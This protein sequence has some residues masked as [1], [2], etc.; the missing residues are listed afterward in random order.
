MPLAVSV[1]GLEF[2]QVPGGYKYFTPPVASSVSPASGPAY[3]GTVITITGF[4]FGAA[5]QPECRFD[6]KVEATPRT[7]EGRGVSLDLVDLSITGGE[8]VNASVLNETHAWCISPGGGRL[9]TSTQAGVQ[10]YEDIGV[11]LSLN[12]VWDPVEAVAKIPW[13]LRSIPI[14]SGFAP[15]SGPLSGGTLVSIHGYAFAKGVDYRCRFGSINRTVF[16]TFDT[17]VQQLR[18]RAPPGDRWDVGE[19]SAA[20]LEVSLNGQQYTST[21]LLFTQHAPFAPVRLRPPRGETLGGSLVRVDFDARGQSTPFENILCRFGAA[22]PSV[23]LQHTDDWALC[24]APPSYNARAVSFEHYMPFTDANNVTDGTVKLTTSGDAEVKGGVLRLTDPFGPNDYLSDRDKINMRSGAMGSAVLTLRRPYN[25]LFWFEVQFELLMGSERT[26]G[27]H[28]V[29]VCLG[30]LNETEAFGEEGAGLGLRILFRSSREPLSL[31]AEPLVESIEVWYDGEPLRNVRLGTW[32][33]TSS[34]VRVVIRHDADGLH[35]SHDGRQWIKDYQVRGWAPDKTWRLGFGARGA[36]TTFGRGPAEVYKR[37]ERHW[38]DDLRVSSGLLIAEATTPVTLSFN[39]QQY[40]PVPVEFRY[41]AMP[42]VSSVTPSTGPLAGGTLVTVS[43]SKL[44][45]GRSDSDRRPPPS[46]GEDVNAVPPGLEETDSHALGYRCRFNREPYYDVPQTALPRNACYPFTSTLSHADGDCYWG[47]QV[48]NATYGDQFAGT[49]WSLSPGGPVSSYQS[50]PYG[51]DSAPGSLACVTPPRFDPLTV[52]L[53]LSLNGQQ[54]TV[55]QLPFGFYTESILHTLWPLGGPNL[56]ETFVVINASYLSNGSDYRCRFFLTTPMAPHSLHRSESAATIDDDA[57]LVRCISPPLPS[58]VHSDYPTYPS[59]YM[60]RLHV[61]KNGQ[62]YDLAGLPFAYYRQPR[63]ILFDPPGGPIEGNTTVILYGAYS[64]GHTKFCRFGASIVPATLRQGPP[65]RLICISPSAENVSLATTNITHE[66]PVDL[67]VTLNGQQ[68]DRLG[69]YIYYDRPLFDLLSPVSGPAAGQTQVTIVGTGFLANVQPGYDGKH[70]YFCRFGR[71]GRTRA[72]SVAVGTL[73]CDS[74]PVSTVYPLEVDDTNGL[75]RIIKVSLTINDQDYVPV[76]DFQYYVEPVISVVAPPVGPILGGSSLLVTGSSSFAMPEEGREAH[77]ATYVCQVADLRFPATRSLADANQL[78][79][80]VPPLTAEDARRAGFTGGEGLYELPFTVSLNAQQFTPRSPLVTYAPS[81]PPPV[82]EGSGEANASSFAP[83][84]LNTTLRA[85]NFTYVGIL[86]PELSDGVVF[87]APYNLPTSGPVDGNTTVVVYGNQ[88]DLTGGSHYQCKIGP[89]LINATFLPNVPGRGSGVLCVTVPLPQGAYPVE[90]TLNG[91][92]FTNS[93]RDGSLSPRQFVVYEPPVFSDTFPRS[94]PTALSFHL[95]L[96]GTRF[97]NGSDYICRFA[98]T[99]TLQDYEPISVVDENNSTNGTNSSVM[100]SSGVSSSSEGES[101]IDMLS[102]GRSPD[103]PLPPPCC[104][105]LS[106]APCLGDTHSCTSATFV[107]D[108]ELRCATPSV[109]SPRVMSVRVTLN[110]Q[111]YAFGAPGVLVYPSPTLQHQIPPRSA[112]GGGT[113]VLVYGRNF[114]PTATAAK[115]SGLPTV[116]C[117]FGAQKVPAT[118]ISANLIRCFAPPALTTGAFNEI[119]IDS[120]SIAG[121]TSGTVHTKGQSFGNVTSRMLE[122]GTHGCDGPRRAACHTS[123]LGGETGLSLP[124]YVYG[125]KFGL[126]GFTQ[127]SHLN[128]TTASPFILYEGARFEDGRLKL[129]R[130][131]LSGG[132]TD[133]VGFATLRH[134]A[135][136][137]HPQRSFLFDFDLR[138]GGFEA[139]LGG[140]GEGFAISYGDVPQPP[141][142]IGERGVGLGL[143]ILF[144]TYVHDQLSVMWQGNIMHTLDVSR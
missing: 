71:H 67:Y 100:A 124:Y 80:V 7:V 77:F 60:A 12:G 119:R 3:G 22:S 17:V 85:I 64:G 104:S 63:P 73:R 55:D 144:R 118:A 18:C 81:P 69:R 47:S 79:C 130:S 35:V 24:E 31:G 25:A 99:S 84:I 111:Q 96:S 87:Q 132:P 54:F 1:N 107:S 52:S 56:G 137:A 70:Q 93:T 117:A 129:T 9:N 113:S 10:P 109:A 136:F 21:G 27:G 141:K 62:N 139:D 88:R 65:E 13:L 112:A 36:S 131:I 125:R 28:G 103:A 91:Q 57:G 142:G 82:D 46:N 128:L 38:I 11:M 15:V 126:F 108:T 50:V 92:Q 83:V 90:V 133:E 39:G 127:L 4:G 86:V 19:A 30:N 134:E 105:Q 75:P 5:T 98:H 120:S 106:S 72:T 44:D 101:G 14:V 26:H 45:A 140:G 23:P 68:Y 74:P 53:E 59:A 110:G 29:S 102:W 76:S 115:P 51:A 66:R 78:G 20:A 32:L 48:V 2:T 61:T 138:M 49:I 33:R 143:R 8:V 114:M 97:S 16:A 121:E 58:D 94:G 89:S 95:R 42:S 123:K 34:W 122:L 41:Y 135:F 43:G 6:G 37:P 40:A 116:R